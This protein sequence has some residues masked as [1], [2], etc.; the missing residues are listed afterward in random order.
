MR[1]DAPR[2][3]GDPDKEHCVTLSFKAARRLGTGSALALQLTLDVWQ[4]ARLR[5]QV[6]GSPRFI[7]SRR[8]N[9]CLQAIAHTEHSEYVL[10]A[11]PW[12]S[13]LADDVSHA[14]AP[15]VPVICQGQ[16]L[17]SAARP[18]QVRCRR[19][20]NR[21]RLQA[22]A[23]SLQRCNHCWFCPNARSACT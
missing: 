6:P 2:L 19:H 12:C 23:A 4:A 3:P 22:L 8:I 11:Q 20:H 14:A 16:R 13:L 18:K 7:R 10:L 17:T 15:V 5:W 1:R 9:Q 21:Q